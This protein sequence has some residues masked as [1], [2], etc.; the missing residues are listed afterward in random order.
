MAEAF[1]ALDKPDRAQKL[2]AKAAALFERFNEAF[3]DEELG[4]VRSMATRKRSR[5]SRPMPG[6]AYGPGSCPASGQRRWWSA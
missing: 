6:I 1:D 3:W 5:P 2:R 4:Y